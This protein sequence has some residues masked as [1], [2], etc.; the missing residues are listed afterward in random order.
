MLKVNLKRGVA[1][2]AFRLEQVLCSGLLLVI[3]SASAQ[4]APCTNASLI[5]AYGRLAT[6]RLAH[7]K[8]NGTK[9]RIMKPSLI[10]LIGIACAFALGAMISPMAIAS[11]TTSDY[12]WSE[13]VIPSIGPIGSAFGIN[14]H[15]QVAVSNADGSK[16]GI[17]RKG[18]FTPLTPPP[19]G[20][21][22]VAATGINNAG[23]IVGNAFSP[24][25]PTHQQGFIL[26]G[27]RYAFYSRP[28]WDN[29]SG[30]AISNTGLVTG[31][32]YDDAQTT[33]AGFIYDPRTGTF[34]DATPPGSGVYFSVTQG[35][36]AA[37]RISGDGWLP[38]GS[39]R[40]GFVWQ[41]GTLIQGKVELAPFLSQF[42]VEEQNSAARG[43]NDAGVTVGF[44][45]PPTVGFVGN[46]TRGFS[47]LV[48]PGGDAPGAQV[49]CEGINNASQVVCNVTDT[50]GNTRAFIGS[51][52]K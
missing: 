12:S 41:Q 19:A 52:D 14:D 22:N 36:N 2:S 8:H 28:G 39:E 23:A 33:F 35:M 44:T 4:A 25:D 26:I 16:T 15:D 9:G 17:Y 6:A 30:R 32:S 13:I 47:L 27:S 18:I 43:I 31:Y 7:L 1:M 24:A 46:E 11:G 48:P 3:A 38:D 40:Y 34:T 10:Q 45:Y 5:G 49:A 29:T 42:R 37:G 51:P 21:S 50:A 20:Y